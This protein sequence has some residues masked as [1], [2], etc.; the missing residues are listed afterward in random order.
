ME[1]TISVIGFLT[2]NVISLVFYFH[3][4]YIYY[5]YQESHNVKW[6]SVIATL[7]IVSAS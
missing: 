1:V 2:I 7:E 6:K 5:T 4:F 3:L